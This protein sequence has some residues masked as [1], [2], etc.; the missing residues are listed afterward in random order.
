[1]WKSSASFPLPTIWMY[2]AFVPN[3]CNAWARPRS[4]L[5]C[6]APAKTR[7]CA[8]SGESAPTRDQ[9]IPVQVIL[10][11]VDERQRVVLRGEPGFGEAGA[12]N[13]AWRVSA[14]QHLA[15][16]GHAVQ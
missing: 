1:M 13:S 10:R 7:T 15:W 8:P 9:I 4:T 2:S 3:G 5:L 6:D 12:L 11:N 14:A 16:T